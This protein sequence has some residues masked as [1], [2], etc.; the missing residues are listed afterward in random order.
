MWRIFCRDGCGWGWIFVPCSSLIRWPTKGRSVPRISFTDWSNGID[1]CIR[2]LQACPMQMQVKF[3]HWKL[4][5]SCAF[6]FQ[7]PPKNEIN[8]RVVQSLTEIARQRMMEDDVE[9]YRKNYYPGAI[10]ILKRTSWSF[11]AL[12]SPI[13]RHMNVN[14]DSLLCNWLW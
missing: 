5:L 9:T 11:V 12:S 10:N 3:L 6:A 2:L 13:K 1:A 7:P 8:V 4:V 14:C